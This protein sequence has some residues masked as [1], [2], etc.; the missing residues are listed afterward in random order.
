[1][2]ICRPVALRSRPKSSSER[3]DLP[4]RRRKSST[5]SSARAMAGRLLPMR[6]W[7]RSQQGPPDAMVLSQPRG[8]SESGPR[9]SMACSA[10]L[11]RR[12][13]RSPSAPLVSRRSLGRR[14]SGDGWASSRFRRSRGPGTPAAGAAGLFVEEAACAPADPPRIPPR[15]PVLREGDLWGDLRCGGTDEPARCFGCVRTPPISHLFP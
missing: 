7:A 8:M 14:T 5:R 12:A 10:R 15:A 2:R 4:R 1:M 6:C 3:L 13:S 9:K 11:D